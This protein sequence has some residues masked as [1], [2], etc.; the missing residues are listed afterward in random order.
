MSSQ[1]TALVP[2]E[3]PCTSFDAPFMQFT[4]LLHEQQRVSEA[5]TIHGGARWSD[6]PIERLLADGLWPVILRAAEKMGRQART[7][8]Q[9]L[10]VA[11]RLDPFINVGL[12]VRY[13]TIADAAQ[14]FITEVVRPIETRIGA[15]GADT[16]TPITR[17]WQIPAAQF[18]A[19][20]IRAAQEWRDGLART[21]AE[22]Q[23]DDEADGV[24]AITII[25]QDSKALDM[26]RLVTALDFASSESFSSKWYAV[27]PGYPAHAA[28]LRERQLL[29]RVLPY[30]VD[31][32]PDGMYY[33]GAPTIAETWLRTQ[34]LLAAAGLPDREHITSGEYT[35]A[36]RALRECGIEAAVSAFSE[37]MRHRAPELSDT[38]L[39]R[40]N[41]EAR[42]VAEGLLV[43]GEVLTDAAVDGLLVLVKPE[44]VTL[45]HMEAMGVATGISQIVDASTVFAENYFHTYIF[46]Q[47]KWE[48]VTQG[49]VCDMC[50]A[51]VM[52]MA[53][54]AAGVA[55]MLEGRRNTVVQWMFE[56]D[57]VNEEAVS[58]LLEAGVIDLTPAFVAQTVSLISSAYLE[59]Y[60]PN[61]L[62]ELERGGAE[63]RLNAGVDGHTILAFV[64][65]LEDAAIVR[66]F[67]NLSLRERLVRVACWFLDLT[68]VQ[69]PTK[70][71]RPQSKRLSRLLGPD[72]WCRFVFA[73][74]VVSRA[75]LYQHPEK[76]D[77]DDNMSTMRWEESSRDRDFRRGYALVLAVPQC[78][79]ATLLEKHNEERVLD[80]FWEARPDRAER[81]EK[82]RCDRERY[83]RVVEEQ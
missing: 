76:R 18:L 31:M 1:M 14:A 82:F 47:I 74:D 77:T 30:H 9:I 22:I 40:V 79:V 55:K 34:L 33:C 21:L 73:G 48:E 28:R 44:E 3:E 35:A 11:W 75:E 49:E 59:R 66:L 68:T 67:A 64:E 51:G 17:I 69:R 19:G 83:F 50:Y 13:A 27:I 56:H 29:F 7:A 32:L 23:R 54:I 45:S 15:M 4:A 42:V 39:E 24:R 65:R 78:N 60:L 61:L 80:W 36:I 16:T 10:E 6:L 57:Y 58:V 5:T 46:P 26:S 70:D 53:L 8:Q 38:T 2:F 12:M 72:E 62:Y 20:L 81:L 52:P 25:G 41:A 43:W 37:R 63:A 71:L